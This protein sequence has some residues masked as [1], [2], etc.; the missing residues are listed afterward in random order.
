MNRIVLL[1]S[2]CLLLA[3]Q[4]IEYP[5]LEGEAALSEIC[6]T[7]NPMQ[8][9]PWLKEMVDEGQSDSES[10]YCQ[11]YKV[12]QGTYN[13]KQ[14]FVAQISGALCCTCAGNTVY[15]CEGELLFVCEPDKEEKISDLKEIWSR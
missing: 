8:D 6:G 11:L 10:Y 7:T 13:N 3:C 5:P 1:L 12:E 9:L 4:E 14:V 15:D 2:L